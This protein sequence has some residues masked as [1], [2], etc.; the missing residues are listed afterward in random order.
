MK[1]C[2]K[3]IKPGEFAMFEESEFDKVR[4]EYETAR[5]TDAGLIK[6]DKLCNGVLGIKESSAVRLGSFVDLF[7]NIG[8]KNGE[9]YIINPLVIAFVAFVA[10]LKNPN[11][12]SCSDEETQSSTVIPGVAIFLK[13]LEHVETQKKEYEYSMAVLCNIVKVVTNY[14]CWCVSTSSGNRNNFFPKPLG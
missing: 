11:G 13:E 4:T 14:T 10:G 9:P 7:K 8:V 3:K 6:F 12:F 2:E 1:K 5:E